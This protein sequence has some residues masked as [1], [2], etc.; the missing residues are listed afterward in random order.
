MQNAQTDQLTFI[1]ALI[2]I[3]AI[4]MSG[5]I[6]WADLATT[7]NSQH[8]NTLHLTHTEWYVSYSLEVYS[9]ALSH[10][11]NGLHKKLHDF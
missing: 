2:D 3:K 8:E 10:D 4:K 7:S 1:R 11:P 6:S 9:C 5:L